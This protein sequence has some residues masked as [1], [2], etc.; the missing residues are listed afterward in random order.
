MPADPLFYDTA[1]KDPYLL[2]L[3]MELLWLAEES[4]FA[5]F[6][7]HWSS[8]T[9]P[10]TSED[11]DWAFIYQYASAHLQIQIREH[12]VLDIVMDSPEKNK[13]KDESNQSGQQCNHSNHPN[14]SS[15]HAKQLLL[16]SR[17]LV[18]QDRLVQI[19]FQELSK[20]VRNSLEQGVRRPCMKHILAQRRL[21]ARRQQQSSSLA[22]QQA[23]DKNPDSFE[24]EAPAAESRQPAT[25]EALE[26]QAGVET[27]LPQQPKTS[28]ATDNDGMAVITNHLASAEN[29]DTDMGGVEENDET[30]KQAA[31]RQ[32]HGRAVQQVDPGT[33]TVVRV[34]ADKTSA[35][36][37]TGLS[38]LDIARAIQE[39]PHSAGNFLWQYAPLPNRPDPVGNNRHETNKESEN[40]VLPESSINNR[41]QQSMI[42]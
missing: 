4:K 42:I 35:A 8:T 15:P 3:E 36:E 29:K 26:G 20:Q 13:N 19:R 2:P 39:E 38:V 7:P 37:A 16:P 27:A 28:M 5:Q 17:L 1:N 31:T 33:R 21:E 12:F 10:N 40:A 34:F 23:K 14:H 41:Y 32:R 6:V 25:L 18:R 9:S 30:R 24:S 22:Q 11:Y